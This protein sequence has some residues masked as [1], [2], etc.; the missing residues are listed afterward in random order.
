M[1]T[2]QQ[3]EA[4]WSVVEECLVR[5]H[6]FPVPLAQKAVADSLSYLAEARPGVRTDMVFHAEPFDV[7]ATIA[8]N[9][10]SLADVAEEY[11]VMMDAAFP[12]RP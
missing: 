1:I 11:D 3:A 10:L 4:F 2:V 8:D 6:A 9:P 5:F 7:A 12:G